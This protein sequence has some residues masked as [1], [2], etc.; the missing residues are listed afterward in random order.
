MWEGSILI[1]PLLN[2]LLTDAD[3]ICLKTHS[4]AIKLGMTYHFH[5]R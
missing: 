2:K 4:L 3:I 5:I 1:L